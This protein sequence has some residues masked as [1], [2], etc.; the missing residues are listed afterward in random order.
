MKRKPTPLQH[1]RR[2]PAEYRGLAW[3]GLQEKMDFIFIY[4]FIWPH[5][6]SRGILV[7]RPGIEPTPLALE[8]RRLN[9]W[10]V[11]EVPKKWI[12]ENTGS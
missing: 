5:R 3:I 9:H 6:A 2:I 11:R 8:V 7:P 1:P 10:T 12:L 4:L